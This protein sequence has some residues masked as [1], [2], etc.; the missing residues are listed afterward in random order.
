L[1]ILLAGWGACG[2]GTCA[3]DLNGDGQV[4]GADLGILLSGWGL[5]AD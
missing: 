5:C 2:T 4:N 3:A 1:G